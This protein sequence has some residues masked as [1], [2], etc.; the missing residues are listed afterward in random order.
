M[1]AR[2]WCFTWNNP[3]GNPSFSDYPNI[4]YAVYQR[5][6]G[7]EGTEHFQGYVEFSKVQRITAVKKILASAHWEVRKGTREQARDYCMKAESRIS[8]PVEYG[9]WDGKKQGKRNDLVRLYECVKEGK[10]NKVILDEMP[11]T[12][13]RYYKAVAHVRHVIATPR[14]FKTEVYVIWGKTGLGK[15][16][17]CSEQSSTAYRKQRGDWWDMYDGES[18]VIID[19]FYGWIKYDTMLRLCD[20]YSMQVEMKGGFINFAPKRIYITSNMPPHQWYKNEKCDFEALSRR[21]TKFLH[22]I[23]HDKFDTYD[24]WN[25]FIEKNRINPF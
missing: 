7:E 20:R 17:Y 23:D 13:M 22:F 4:T 9:E 11:A 19:D 21:V 2:N 1:S 10:D 12:Y 18:D 16:K 6:S 8:D 3:I 25:D 15:T 5:E 14:S 24:T